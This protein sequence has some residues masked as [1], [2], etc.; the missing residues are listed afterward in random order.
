MPQQPADSSALLG[1]SL[2]CARLGDLVGGKGASVAL[3]HGEAGIGKS[4]LL[5][6]ALDHAFRVDTRILNAAGT[7]AERNLPFAGLHQ[8]LRPVLEETDPSPHRRAAL[9]ET[10]AAQE[11]AGATLFR[12]A[13]VV[14]DLLTELASRQ[15]VLIVVDDVQWWDR[16]SRDVLI[17][18]GRR[19]DD[20]PIAMVVGARE[21]VPDELAQVAIGAGWLDLSL[22]R[23]DDDDA[24][25]LLD[26]VAP[27]LANETRRLVLV[28][29]AGNP[30]ALTELPKV[31]AEHGPL[32]DAGPGPPLPIN[33]RL[34]AA[35]AARLPALPPTTRLLALLAAA[36]DSDRLDE[37]LTAGRLLEGAGSLHDLEPA[38]SAGLLSV[39][40]DTVRFRHPLVR[41][42]VYHHAGSAARHDAHG[43]L[44]QT[45]GSADRR[46]W[47]AAAAAAGPDE[48]V[49]EQLEA[50]AERARHAGASDTAA[51]ALE[52]AARL[53]EPPDRAA[54]RLLR[55]AELWYFHGDYERA[56]QLLEALD[57]GALDQAERVRLDWGR[58]LLSEAGAWSGA[59]H[60]AAIA[61]IARR[62]GAA[63]DTERAVRMLLSISLRCWWSNPDRATR[64]AVAEAA[65]AL[66]EGPDD[67]THL[68]VT[69]LAAPLERGRDVLAAYGRIAVPDRHSDASLLLSLGLAGTAVGDHPRAM[70]MLSAAVTE[71]R[72]QGRTGVLSEALVAL[73]WAE[74]LLGRLGRAEVAAEEGARLSRETRLPM[75][76]ATAELARAAARGLRGDAVAADALVD[77]AEHFLMDTGANPLLAQ[78]RVARSFAA[79]GS[80]RFD[81][82]F[83]QLSRVFAPSD[84]CYHQYLRT[85]HVA[86]LAESAVYSDRQEEAARLM[87]DLEALAEQTGSPI[88][89]AG[90]LVA[91]PLLAE[92]DDVEGL[93]DGALGD[94]LTEWP[95][96]RARLLL[97]YGMWLRRRRRIAEARDPLRTARDTFAALGMPPWAERA[98]QELRAAGEADRQRPAAAWEGLTAQ[99][100]QIASMAAA[101]LTNRQIGER[102]FLSRRTIGAHLY[103]IFPKLGISSRAQLAA[104]LADATVVAEEG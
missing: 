100:L 58:D 49:A 94:G 40:G 73:A 59:T 11:A 54:E 30:L 86:Q 97:G 50:V 27:G 79:V 14:L 4:A 76:E 46:A 43:A 77:P 26:T 88:L 5:D 99:E 37:V 102:L 103:H 44:A 21:P 91:R 68:V 66:R 67:P 60:L 23:L 6:W 2:E 10:L 12:T 36:H 28:E 82:G 95:L 25:V 78:V 22:A 18:V 42:A 24:A 71:S 75:W 90:L 51:K 84:I 62:M 83:A 72:R 31:V 19:L 7:P 70:A 57:R 64:M 63:G 3:V 38:I 33:A 47:H 15:E 55:A 1:R 85:F 98:G 32:T 61:G 65:D 41:S 53:S 39:V 8:L 29:A 56:Q 87:Q 45:A 34:E 81:D 13:M 17:F 92:E 16:P 69:A 20:D 80:G 9:L 101:G 52:R 74:I 48:S 96:H 89:R 35:F 93:Y 104:A